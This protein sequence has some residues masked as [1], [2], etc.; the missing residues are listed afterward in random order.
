MESQMA[1]NLMEADRLEI[2][3]LQDNYIDVAAMDGTEMVHRA[4]PLKDGEIKNSILAEHGFSALVSVNSGGETRQV[5]FDFGFSE[6]G[7]A[8]NVDALNADL[9]G[10]EALILSHGHMDHFG[11]LK[12]LVERIGDKNIELILHPTAFRRQRYIKASEDRHINLPPLNKETIRAAG[13][14]IV[15]SK[16]PRLLA[17]GLLLFLG[18]IPRETKFEKGFPRMH[19]DENGQ[20]HWDPIEDDT[21]IVAYVRGKGLVILSGCAHSGIVNTVKY[22]QK[23]TGIEKIF[24]VM[25]GFH[26]TGADFEPIIEPTIEALKALGPEYVIPT[27]C[28]GR[29]ATMSLEKEMPDQF[30]LNMSGTRMVFSS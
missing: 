23:T 13:V 5:L 9:S 10:V 16:D 4:M 12:S 26:L 3:T 7:A 29:K 28:T 1:I 14:S 11:G 17:D 18:E 21:A 19:Y 27:H 24:V 2:L 30:L 15:E 6:Q 20:S 8:S 25:G 22:A